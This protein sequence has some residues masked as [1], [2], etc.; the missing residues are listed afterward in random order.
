MPGRTNT[1]SNGEPI[2]RIGCG[3]LTTLEPNQTIVVS[4]VIAN[5]RAGLQ[6]LA[7]NYGV[8]FYT[9]YSTSSGDIIWIEVNYNDIPIYFRTTGAIV[10]LVLGTDE[11]EQ[12]IL[13]LAENGLP[14]FKMEYITEF[15][16]VTI[17]LISS[18][19]TSTNALDL[20]ICGGKS[21]SLGEE[22]VNIPSVP[23]VSLRYSD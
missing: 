10:D 19:S 15:E 11:S 7:N 9:L 18:S 5:V 3:V 17:N 13:E 12:S 6:S 21:F 16:P 14:C 1:V 23:C 22:N 20:I 2:K 8:R 4:D